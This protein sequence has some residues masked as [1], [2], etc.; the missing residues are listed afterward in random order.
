MNDSLT[1]YNLNLKVDSLNII[2]QSRLER[3]QTSDDVLIKSV[4]NGVIAEGY[5]SDVISLQLGVFLFI[6]GLL[7]LISWKG[8]IFFFN[9][10]IKELKHDTDEQ[11]TKNINRITEIE[12]SIN[13]T[14]WNV[15]KANYFIALSHK[16][17]FSACLHCVRLIEHEVDMY[18]GWT[19]GVE[20]WLRLTKHRSSISEPKDIS[21]DKIL[22]ISEILNKVKSNDSSTEKIKSYIEE[23]LNN[24]YRLK[25]KATENNSEPSGD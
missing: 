1:I 12:K 18:E 10:K 13:N 6:L 25:S 14:K 15:L 5:F 23:I 20:K 2:T 4:E 7:A 24:L 21:D 3:L 9:K 16:L 22:E 17:N 11:N 19:E 8:I